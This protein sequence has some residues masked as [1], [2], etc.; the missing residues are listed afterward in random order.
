MASGLGWRIFLRSLLVQSSWSFSNM[1]SLGFFLM[2]APALARRRL[3]ADEM[4]SAA[5]RRLRSF[6]THPYLA[7]LVAATV[8][9]EEELGADESTV[10][11]L[12]NS[13]MCTLG[14]VGDEFF[15]GVLRPFAALAALPAAFAGVAWAPLVLLALYD[16]P[17][18]GIRAVGI[19][20]GLARGQ[21]VVALLQHRPLSRA[22]PALRTAT[23]LLVGYIVGSGA[24][25]PAWGIL[26]GFG[27]FSAAAA[28]A[29]FALLLGFADGGLGLG[30]VLAG[31]SIL[32][33]LGAL[34]RLVT[35]S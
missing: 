4:T 25:D 11:F 18:L 9:R 19:R 35:A 20:L 2:T 16:V 29:A 26:P 27:L 6:N 31:A 14:G 34:L 28:V 1:Q 8:I 21:G 13:L 33:V 12:K 17:H 24:S 32:T 10:D 15:W 5:L 22:L 3:P 30:R 7:G 23:A